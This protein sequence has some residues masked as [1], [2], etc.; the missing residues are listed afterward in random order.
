MNYA[1]FTDGGSR[2][3]PGP[4]AI[5]A[6][7]RD[8]HGRLVDEISA[9]IGTTTNNQAEYRA[10]LAGL[11]LALQR[12]VAHL[13]CY[14]DSELVVRQLNGEYRVKDRDLKPLYDRVTALRVQFERISFVHIPR[15]KNVDADALV[16]KALDDAS[17]SDAVPA[18]R[19]P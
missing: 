12:R 4:A 5:G 2:G 14:M 6:V 1:L 15:H 7:L 19:T 18:N 16:N 10:L 17:G 8:T 13:N 11:E 9:P 3:N